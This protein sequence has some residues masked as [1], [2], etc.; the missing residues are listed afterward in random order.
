MAK[1]VTSEQ[2]EA[3]LNRV[4]SMIEKSNGSSG[5]AALPEISLEELRTMVQETGEY[6]ISTVIVKYQTEDEKLP[7]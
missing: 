5:S 7:D 3:A 1:A 4:K 6:P 2:L